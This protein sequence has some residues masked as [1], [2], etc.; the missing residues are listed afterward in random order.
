MN[1]PPRRPIRPTTPTAAP[2]AAMGAAPTATAQVESAEQVV[3]WKCTLGGEMDEETYAYL[4]ALLDGEARAAVVA[5]MRGCEHVI[6][7]AIAALER[8]HRSYLDLLSSVRRQLFKGEV[9]ANGLAALRDLTVG[10]MTM[11]EVG[12]A[13]R[14]AEVSHL[15]QQPAMSEV[16][17]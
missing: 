15:V 5:S 12:L 9:D 6:D 1:V 11:N 3:D 10:L 4:M 2:Q 7:D 14:V 16:A 8:R 13:R 17:S